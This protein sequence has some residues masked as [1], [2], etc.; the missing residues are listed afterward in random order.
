MIGDEDWFMNVD[1]SHPGLDI[2]KFKKT[3]SGISI[4]PF[5]FQSGGVESKMNFISG[6]AGA[7]M[8]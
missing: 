2:E 6:F 1:L 7:T 5:V 4:T 8:T 3:A